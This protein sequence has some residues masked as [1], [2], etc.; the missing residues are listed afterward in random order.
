MYV[1]CT[2]RGTPVLPQAALCWCVD[3]LHGVRM[4]YNRGGK[5][6]QSDGRC[7]TASCLAAAN[8][9]YLR[10]G[11][12]F[13]FIL[14]WKQTILLLLDLLLPAPAE[15]VLVHSLREKPSSDILC[16]WPTLTSNWN[17]E[18]SPSRGP[19]WRSKMYTYFY[20]SLFPKIVSI[21][22]FLLR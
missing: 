14:R 1:T 3:F 5:Q 8:L 21:R 18:E 19:A 15:D 10:S 2:A 4:H 6:Q 11:S 20:N 16:T 17:W 7:L 12:V 22:A 13:L 9:I